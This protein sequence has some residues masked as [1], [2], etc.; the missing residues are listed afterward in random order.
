[1]I[2]AKHHKRY[3]Q[4]MATMLMSLIMM[5][6]I[7]LISLYAA[8]VS[9]IEQKIS[10]NHFRAKQAFESAQAGMDASIDKIT[11]TIIDTLPT[12]GAGNKVGSEAD[13]P[14]DPTLAAMFNTN[15][16][17]G[18]YKVSF[19]TVDALEPD[20]VKVT[21]YGFSGDNGSTNINDANQVIEQ[22]VETTQVLFH[23]PH[24]AIISGGSVSVNGDVTI[25][26]TAPVTQNSLG[27][28]EAKPTIWA[29]NNISDTGASITT[30]SGDDEFYEDSRLQDLINSSATPDPDDVQV[31][32]N[33]DFFANYF[34]D[35]KLRTK[36]RNPVVNCESGC[37]TSDFISKLSDLNMIDANGM[38]LRTQVIW[39][40]AYDESTGTAATLN[41][42]DNFT[43]GSVNQSVVL[44]V[45]GKFRMSDRNAEVN[46]LVYT[47]DDFNNGTGR[48][49]IN[50][51]LISEG[52]VS[53][54]GR[55]NFTYDR[56]VI[57]NL[58]TSDGTT[59]YVRIAG[60]WK[61][62]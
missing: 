44:Y 30:S 20:K 41:F 17:F 25:T 36:N 49:T 31:T 60:T 33:E 54:S 19:S 47:T 28:D 43:L 51:S 42:N 21:V 18:H 22:I 45:E 16:G 57:S 59:R 2:N 35:N 15:S 50:G 34:N 1:M 11:A 24:S 14:L 39:V 7:S 3:Q 37:N 13:I 32:Q 56:D 55:M 26:N 10:G 46:G 61:D 48:G 6:T 52:N 38:N 5:V 62:F 40:D 12:N 8:Q 27:D 29:A 9:V 23:Q 4:G 58:M 53:T